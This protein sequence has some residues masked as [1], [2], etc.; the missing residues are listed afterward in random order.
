MSS[1]RTTRAEVFPAAAPHLQVVG[2]HFRGAARRG[3]CGQRSRVAAGRRA[4]PAR[5]PVSWLLVSADMGRFGGSRSSVGCP[6]A[7]PLYEPYGLPRAAA[8]TSQQLCTE[9]NAPRRSRNASF[10][11]LYV[12]GHCKTTS[13]G[14]R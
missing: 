8:V 12:R 14:S 11:P 1:H 2:R 9:S 3:A 6:F 10:I 5:C 7:H 4:H 13:K